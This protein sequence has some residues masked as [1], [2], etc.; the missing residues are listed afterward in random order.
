V[1]TAWSNRAVVVVDEAAS[2]A[3]FRGVAILGDRVYATDF[4]NARV[5][6]YDS[7]WRRVRRPGAFTDASIPAWYAPFGIHA[8]DG[9]VFVTY[10]GRAPVNGNDDP[11]GGYV[12]EFDRGGRLVARVEH[13][14][15]N[16]PWGVALAPRSF[17][18]FGGDLLVGNFGD[19]HINAFRREGDRWAFAGTLHDTHGKAIEL[20]GLWGIA[21]GNGAMAG[22]TRTLF[23]AS[24]PHV[25][26]G[27]TELGVHGLL[28]SIAPA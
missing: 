4:H 14:P 22:D 18:R 12:D 25:W 7:L 8:I 15:L 17:G 20:S 5:D 1:P 6:M 24:G 21:F 3:V 19:G 26:R 9:H 28:G 27:E 2:A 11:I 23:F 13:A 16:A 10:V